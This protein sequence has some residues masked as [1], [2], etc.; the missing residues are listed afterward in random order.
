MSTADCRKV[1]LI[2]AFVLVD[3]V[4]F[5]GGTEWKIFTNKERGFSIRYPSNWHVYTK[6]EIRATATST[7]GEPGPLPVFAVQAPDRGSFY[8]IVDRVDSPLEPA[9]EPERAR[10]LSELYLGFCG[11]DLSEAGCTKVSERN[12]ELAGQPAVEYVWHYPRMHG[13]VLVNKHWCFSRGSRGFFLAATAAEED[14]DGQDEKFFTPMAQSLRL[15]GVSSDVHVEPSNSHSVRP[16]G[17]PEEAKIAFRSERDGNW[18]IYIMNVDG[19]GVRRL[20]NDP[21]REDMPRW[22]P[23]G[24]QIVFRSERDGNQEIYIMNSDGSHQRRLTNH[25]AKDSNPCFSP[26]GSTILFASKRSG[27]WDLYTMKPDG[28]NQRKL[29]QKE[30]LSGGALYSPEGKRIVFPSAKDGTFDVYI[31]DLR[32]EEISRLTADSCA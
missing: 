16:A 14:F 7:P 21:A 11:K 20:T 9:A 18:E 22:S 31:M 12:T 8:I 32:T 4:C 28:S 10:Y 17:S 6:E 24:K 19:S 13:I 1:V 2:V 25:P 23:D 29:V 30:L 5:G 3:Q 15:L 27:N 26:E